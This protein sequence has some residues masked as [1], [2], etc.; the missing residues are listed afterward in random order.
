MYD[1]LRMKYLIALIILIAPVTVSAETADFLRPQIDTIDR[2][3]NCPSAQ[4]CNAL[5]EITG[6][7]FVNTNRQGGVKVGDV[8]AIIHSWSHNTILASTPQEQLNEPLIVTVDTTIHRPSIDSGNDDI[9]QMLAESVQVALDSIKITDDG[10]RYI[11]AG[12]KYTNPD[13]TYYRDSYWT[14]QLILMMEPSVVRDEILILARGIEP[15]GSVPSAL[16]INPND[17]RIPLWTDHQDAGPF[18]I[19]HVH[20]Y[21]AWTGDM[22]LLD[23]EVN[24]RTIFT[25]ME[26]V[27]TYLSTKDTNGN[28]LPEKPKGSLQDWLDSIPREGEVFSNQ[29]LYYNA[30]RNLAELAE[31]YG[32]P[33]HAT[34]FQRQSLLV[35]H[36]INKQ[37]WNE[38][39]GYYYERCT[40]DGCIE[41]LTNESAMGLLFDVVPED[42]QDRFF[43]TLLNL[44]TAR[45]K[46]IAYGNWGVINAWPLYKGY[47]G[48]D[49]HNGT[50][51]PF[52]D[53][54]NA[55][56]RLKHG[57]NDWFYP[58]TRW[59]T[60]NREQNTGRTLPE[61]LAP[62]DL[63]GGDLQAW[64]VFP[65]T[66][67]LRYGF[68][69]NPDINGQYTL[70]RP[71]IDASFENV[72]IQGKRIAF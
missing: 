18:F 36:F 62:R 44:E 9:D 53:G 71:L 69:I 17:P 39:G 20:D 59:W 15:N 40:N 14:M 67:L 24:G 10:Q 50:D 55:G 13:R 29:V 35:H 22:S 34:A 6:R 49:Y 57:N 2:S 72:Y 31:L 26:D 3:I 52:L 16:P 64:S 41:R 54:I 5:F 27:I 63:D 11:T 8:W 4:T 25:A 51:W 30:I 45:N 60:F 61:Y 56:A 19:M 12:P 46:T 70:K 68:G 58:L 43:N 37:F 65:A 48:Y 42:R 23:E 7:R 21:I 66:A 38:E 47:Q 33:V 1:N 28:L 32:K